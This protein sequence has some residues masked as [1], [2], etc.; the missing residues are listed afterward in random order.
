VFIPDFVNLELLEN[1][2]RVGKLDVYTPSR[3]K[4]RVNGAKKGMR[5]R[6]M[7]EGMSANDSSGFSSLCDY[8]CSHVGIEIAVK[9]T[10]PAAFGQI[11]KRK[12]GFDSRCIRESSP[13][14]N[15]D[16]G[17]VVRSNLQKKVVRVLALG[18]LI[19][20]LWRVEGQLARRG[21]VDGI[22]SSSRPKKFYLSDKSAGI[23]KLESECCGFNR[24]VLGIQI[25]S[26]KRKLPQIAKRGKTLA[27]AAGTGRRL[28]VDGMCHITQMLNVC[29]DLKLSF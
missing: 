8:G 6:D 27:I 23:T 29:C 21:A 10:M 1:P 3:C 22:I 28:L 5:V 7:F 25:M 19:G 26:G 17:P 20:N 14:E 18:D 16:E 4:D 13:V 9:D 12:R 2:K 15:L 24:C 11:C